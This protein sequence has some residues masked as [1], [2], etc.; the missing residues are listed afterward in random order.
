MEEKDSGVATLTLRTITSLS[1]I[2]RKGWESYQV[3]MSLEALLLIHTV[4]EP[5]SLP[6]Q[7]AVYKN[8]FSKIKHFLSLTR[9]IDILHLWLQ[10]IT[11][12]R[13][14]ALIVYC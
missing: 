14:A 4:H 7:C 13:S 1:Q 10:L 5:H 6:W 9:N 11:D 12:S 3:T 2:T 8:E